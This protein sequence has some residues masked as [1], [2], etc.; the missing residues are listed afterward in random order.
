V[1][2]VDCEAGFIADVLKASQV[3]LY[4]MY[5]VGDIPGTHHSIGM[6]GT[7]GADSSGPKVKKKDTPTADSEKLVQAVITR[8]IGQDIEAAQSVG[9]QPRITKEGVVEVWW[10]PSDG[11]P[12]KLRNLRVTVLEP[13]IAST[14]KTTDVLRT[15]AARIHALPTQDVKAKKYPSMAQAELNGLLVAAQSFYATH[16]VKLSVRLL[17]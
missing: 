3:S 14:G 4:A 2:A 9:E 17:T 8:A 15:F 12:A 6:G 16:R 13:E 1:R 5:F 10:T 11:S 7:A